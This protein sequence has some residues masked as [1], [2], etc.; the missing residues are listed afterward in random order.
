MFLETLQDH[1]GKIVNILVN[2]T[3]RGTEFQTF[4]GQKEIF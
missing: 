3:H 2:I 4:Q 1:Y